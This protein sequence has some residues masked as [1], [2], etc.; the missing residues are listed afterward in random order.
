MAGCQLGE[1][2]PPKPSL[3]VDGKEIDYKIGTY[4]WSE[5]GRA[6]DADAIAPPDL[7]EE[8]DFNVVPSKSK[9]LINF[10]YQPSGIEAGIWKNDDVNFERVTNN[11]I[12][13]PKEAG[14]FIYVI[15][16]SWEEGD[17][18]Y[19]FPIKVK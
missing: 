9:M 4:S 6:V 15:H 8:M 10:G 7:V 17:A 1:L 16:A 5:N 3:T 14:S 13:L 2:E 11:T 19:A 18:I 12:I